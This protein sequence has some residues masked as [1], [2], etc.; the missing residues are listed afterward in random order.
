[1][2]II[3]IVGLVAG[4]CTSSSLIPQLVT[5]V[6]KKKATDVSLFMFIV[7]FTGNA[8]WTYYG[9]AKSE[10]PIIITNLIALSLNIVM[11]ILKIKYKKNEK[12][13]DD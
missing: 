7:M 2:D 11:M 1:M 8:L 12:G 10:L 3:E 13:N 9:F 6:K 5:T 4:A